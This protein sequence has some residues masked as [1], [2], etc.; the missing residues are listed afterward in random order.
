MWRLHTNLN[1]VLVDTLESNA[2]PTTDEL[3]VIAVGR[4][5]DHLVIVSIYWPLET[6]INIF[7]TNQQ[8]TR[9]RIQPSRHVHWW[10]QLSG[11]HWGHGWFSTHCRPV[12][13]MLSQAMAQLISTQ[14][15]NRVKLDVMFERI[16]DRRSAFISIIPVG[17]SDRRIVLDLKRFV[18][19]MEES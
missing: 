13:S 12:S 14:A 2:K 17:F 9:E 15:L 3:V 6:C 8:P 7:V 11:C 18:H 5:A 16:A 19:H 10:L 4:D 1:A